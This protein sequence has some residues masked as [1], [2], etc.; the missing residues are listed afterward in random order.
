[1]KTNMNAHYE[2][3]LHSDTLHIT[4]NF[5]LSNERRHTR[6]TSAPVI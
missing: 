3:S 5:S 6:K 2:L 1:M 4:R